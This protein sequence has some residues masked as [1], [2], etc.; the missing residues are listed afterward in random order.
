MYLENV[1]VQLESV[2]FDI[3]KEVKIYFGLVAVNGAPVVFKIFPRGFG[4]FLFLPFVFV[5]LLL[6]FDVLMTFDARLRG[7][8]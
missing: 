4:L 2:F 3:F 7:V 8:R 6:S 5:L 1:D